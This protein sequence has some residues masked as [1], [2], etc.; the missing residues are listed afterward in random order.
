MEAPRI[1][2][3]PAEVIASGTVIAFKDNPVE[4]TLG[5][6]ADT[7]TLVWEF[8]DDP[9]TPAVRMESEVKGPNRLGM[10]LWNQNNPLGS[11]TLTPVEIGTLRGRPL[12]LHFRA[13]SLGEGDRSIQY[14]IYLGEEVAGNG[15]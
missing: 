10:L 9:E 1:K 7:F 3:G 6:A 14:T 5:L 11:G 15:C 2:S 8:R 12:Y 13:Y 4:M